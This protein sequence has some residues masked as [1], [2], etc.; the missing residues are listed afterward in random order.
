MDGWI[1]AILRDIRKGSMVQFIATFILVVLFTGYE[2]TRGLSP[3]T[4]T[5][6]MYWD[7][8]FTEEE[9]ERSSLH[10]LCDKMRTWP[11]SIFVEQDKKLTDKCKVLKRRHILRTSADWKL[12]QQKVKALNAMRPKSNSVDVKSSTELVVPDIAKTPK[13]LG[14]AEINPP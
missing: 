9:L 8:G 12:Y 1:T 6:L 3:I 2:V 7:G 4:T 5:A 11:M 14:M 13:E 10:N